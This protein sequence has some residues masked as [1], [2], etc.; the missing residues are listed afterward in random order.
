MCV[1]IPLMTRCAR[2]NIIWQKFVRSVAF[3]EYFGFLHQYNWNSVG[4]GV[5]HHNHNLNI[6]CITNIQL[7][8]FILYSLQYNI[9]REWYSNTN[10]FLKKTWKILPMLQKGR[11]VFGYLW[12]WLVCFI[13]HH[14]TFTWEIR[15]MD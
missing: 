14:T 12:H 8:S 1:R 15:Y 5:K 3:S 6:W 10:H 11:Y 2:Y 7:I 4:S 9:Y 13:A